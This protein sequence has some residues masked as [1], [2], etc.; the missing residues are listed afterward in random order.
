MNYNMRNFWAPDVKASSGTIDLTA[1]IDMR[2][3][4][5]MMVA[6]SKGKKDGK[7]QLNKQIHEDNVIDEVA[8][9]NN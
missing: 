9:D 2:M 3:E 5:A 7:K 4:H 1:P 8:Y 6:Y